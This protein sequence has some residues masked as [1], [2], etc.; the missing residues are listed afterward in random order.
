M[1]RRLRLFSS[2]TT[3][4]RVMSK[5]LPPAAQS[6][7]MFLALHLPGRSPATRRVREQIIEFA[8]TPTVRSLFIAGPIG[9][10]KSTLAR[11]AALIRRVAPL[12]AEDA[13]TI[14]DTV[15]FTPEGQVDL[16]SI[17]PFYT[18]LSLTGL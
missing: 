15:K 9:A 10:G 3:L 2:T 12:M 14:L 7:E 11:L 4:G 13:K 17:A 5:I 16:R 18:E 1:A 6:I 8:I